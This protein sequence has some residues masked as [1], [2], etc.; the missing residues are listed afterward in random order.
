MSERLNGNS[1]QVHYGTGKPDGYQRR[2][3]VPQMSEAERARMEF[4]REIFEVGRRTYEKEAGDASTTQQR[5]AVRAVD[6]LNEVLEH[7]FNYFRHVQNVDAYARGK[8]GLDGQ[9]VPIRNRMLRIFGNATVGAVATGIDWL[10]VRL[11]KNPESST[12]GTTI[13][14]GDRITFNRNQPGT[15]SLFSYLVGK[16]KTFLH[17]GTPAAA[18]EAPAGGTTA[19]GL[20]KWAGAYGAGMEYI[21]DEA[22]SAGTDKMVQM[23]TKSRAG[24][25]SPLSHKLY[26]ISRLIPVADE[27]LSPTAIESAFRIGSNYPVFG[28]PV[29]ALYRYLN[30]QLGQGTSASK[31]AEGLAYSMVRGQIEHDK[32]MAWQEEN[33]R[34]QIEQNI[35]Q[36]E[37]EGRRSEAMRRG[38][39]TAE[40]L[41]ALEAQ[42]L[43]NAGWLSI[44]AEDVVA[45]RPSKDLK[46]AVKNRSEV[47]E[48]RKKA[49]AAKSSSPSTPSSVGDAAP[50]DSSSV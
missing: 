46:Q 11:I 12:G 34:R 16:A 45:G 39:E 6:V 24:Y 37:A 5:M 22:V 42:S 40:R 20:N 21:L 10:D 44:L 15:E 18:A 38:R 41:Q 43:S 50:T 17:K 1:Q 35:R 19:A 33:V 8:L 23:L 9:R 31:F 13:G 49:A 47:R 7:P 27:F 2:T 14:W 29:E 32:A 25:A 26:N 48:A 4:F 28:A 3:E 30:T 36:Q